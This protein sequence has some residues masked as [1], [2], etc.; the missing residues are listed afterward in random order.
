MAQRQIAQNGR[1]PFGVIV[2]QYLLVRALVK[3]ERFGEPV[4]PVI[5]ISDVD[6]QPS[7]PASIPL[8]PENCTRALPGS[9]C[10]IVPAQ[11]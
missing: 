10:L 1:Q 7:Q 6:F 11:Q 8:P 9:E 4:L 5:D 2:H 3:C